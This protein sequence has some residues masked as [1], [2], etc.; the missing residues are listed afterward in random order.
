MP[1]G[2]E[3]DRMK[4]MRGLPPA[5]HPLY[6]KSCETPTAI[7]SK[8]ARR[9]PGRSRNRCPI[10]IATSQKNRNDASVRAILEKPMC[11]PDIAAIA[12]AAAPAPGPKVLRAS[13][14]TTGIVSVPIAIETRMAAM[15]PIPK[16][17]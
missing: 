8:T 2:L 13:Q 1:R 4:P 16:S 11:G 7:P 5:S 9:A 17:P 12:A 14:P 6:L 3:T 10:P 15:S